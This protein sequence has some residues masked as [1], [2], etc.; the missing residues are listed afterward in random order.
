MSVKAAG[1]FRWIAPTLIAVALVASAGPSTAGSDVDKSEN[2]RLVGSL[3][4]YRYG[5]ELAFQGK[6]G[7]AA[8]IDDDDTG[9]HIL[10]ASGPTPKEIG[11]YACAQTNPGSEVEPLRRGFVAYHAGGAC[12]GAAPGIHIID[13][14]DPRRPRVAAVVEPPLP[15]HTLTVVPG[16]SI[17][18]VSP[19]TVIP[20]GNPREPQGIVDASD[21]FDPK[22]STFPTDGK[23]CHDVAF[24]FTK[25][26]RYGAC[27]GWVETQ[28]WDLSD[29]LAPKT[30]ARIPTPQHNYNHAAAFSD[31]G[32]L[33]VVG[34]EAWVTSSCTGA[35]TYGGLSFYDIRVPAAPLLVGSFNLPRGE[36]VSSLLVPVG[37]S[38][39]TAHM[40][41]FLP[42]TRYL[43]VGWYAGG[44]N[45]LDLSNPSLPKEV[46]HYY[47]GGLA[48]W[49]ALWHRGRIWTS[50]YSGNR[51]VDVFEVDL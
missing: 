13:V 43:A 10:D 14:R 25:E 28:L 36:A 12:G 5:A 39:C 40:Y 47:G 19:A 29:P 42:G 44:L 17:I 26:H 11:F 38:W 46:A 8:E 34:D 41:D 6:L 51:S 27:A 15:E 16:T 48:P 1:H 24:L 45:V 49:S 32:R 33:L 35:P 3:P 4:P 21:P 7:F 22:T 31:D 23:G 2:I 30:I 18:Y 37:D 50:S 20:R 9:L